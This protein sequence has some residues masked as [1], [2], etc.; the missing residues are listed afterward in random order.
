MIWPAWGWRQVSRQDGR[1]DL[2]ATSA[3]R[4]TPAPAVSP[5][6][7]SPTRP[8]CRSSRSRSLVVSSNRPSRAPMRTSTTS[9][10]RCAAT[11][12]SVSPNRSRAIHR[13]SGSR[14]A[15]PTGG[16]RWREGRRCQ[17]RPRVHRH[18][19]T[20]T[21]AEAGVRVPAESE[22]VK[23]ELPMPT[24]PEIPWTQAVKSTLVVLG[25]I[26]YS[27]P[28]LSLCVSIHTGHRLASSSNAP[29]AMSLN[30]GAC[31]RT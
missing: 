29:G 21:E 10:S 20:N 6:R 11:T 1:P 17:H 25:S 2:P 27:W 18:A 15:G 22:Q 9:A 14:S 7:S 19:R 3:T 26:H 24:A 12:T 16:S 30:S 23:A 8:T 13:W 4:S 31:A 5:V 28:S